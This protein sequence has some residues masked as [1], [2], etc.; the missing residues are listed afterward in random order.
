MKPTVNQPNQ[1]AK[2]DY[3]APIIAELQAN[4]LTQSASQIM[5]ESA[6]GYYS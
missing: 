1:V 5:H 2:L 6:N 3:Q 4:E